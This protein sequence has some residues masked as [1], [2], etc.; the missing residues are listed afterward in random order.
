MSAFSLAQQLT[1]AGTH[2]RDG[3]GGQRKGVANNAANAKGRPLAVA[4]SVF[5]F[6]KRRSALGAVR[7]HVSMSGRGKGSKRRPGLRWAIK[8][9]RGRRRE[10]LLLCC[11]R[12]W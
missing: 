6:A 7:G 10:V 5:H 8:E 3:D 12:G 2:D 4:V 9:S 11:P 1:G